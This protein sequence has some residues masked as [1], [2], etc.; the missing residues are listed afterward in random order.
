MTQNKTPKLSNHVN[1]AISCP[2]FNINLNLLLALEALQYRTTQ[3]TNLYIYG[4]F[5]Q[6][7][8]IHTIVFNI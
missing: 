5:W 6:S 1:R 8:Q 2:L 3:L 7:N 4:H